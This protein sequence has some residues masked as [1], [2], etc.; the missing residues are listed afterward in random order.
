M[1]GSCKGIIL[2]LKIYLMNHEPFYWL[3]LMVIGDLGLH[4]PNAVCHVEEAHRQE[5][6]YVIIHLLQMEVPTAMDGQMKQTL[7]TAIHVSIF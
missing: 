5:R 7:V 3:Q 4:G 6:D 1:L 2:Q